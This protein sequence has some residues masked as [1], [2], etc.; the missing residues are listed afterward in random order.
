LGGW[1]I[2]VHAWFFRKL[3]GQDVQI[4]NFGR[5]T[6]ASLFQLSDPAITANQAWCDPAPAGSQEL[7]IRLSGI[8]SIFAGS[9]SLPMLKD[10]G[11]A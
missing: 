3:L 10:Q 4:S 1:P 11:H 6:K 2:F 8:K 7:M 9:M 5:P